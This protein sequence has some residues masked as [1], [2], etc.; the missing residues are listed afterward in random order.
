MSVAR[1]TEL[2]ARTLSV[3]FWHLPVLDIIIHRDWAVDLI[4]TSFWFHLLISV[5]LGV[6]LTYLF[7]WKPFTVPVNWMLNPW[8]SLQKLRPKQKSSE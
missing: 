6:G 4:H 7:S 2:G 3:Y 5:V 8:P 1:M